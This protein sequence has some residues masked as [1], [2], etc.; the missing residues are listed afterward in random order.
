MKLVGNQIRV[1]ATDLSNHLACRHLTSLDLKVAR[2]ERKAP[3]WAAPDLVVIQQL[4]LRHEAEYL[5]F[6]RDVRK[7]S[8]FELPKEG[9]PKALAEETQALMAQ[10]ADVIA[11][12]ALGDNAWYGRPD[13]LLRVANA[14]GKWK[15]SYEVQD[16]KLAKETKGTTILQIALYSELVGRLQR[17]EPEFMWVIPPGN[18]FAGVR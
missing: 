12:G 18:D 15:W 13:V 10:G 3:D 6:L 14:S 11:Q 17:S 8:V 2:G 5:K 9:D 1:S 4:G 7:L 16:T